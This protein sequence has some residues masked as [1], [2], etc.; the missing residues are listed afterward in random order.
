MACACQARVRDP[1]GT[2]PPTVSS[3]P[4]PCWHQDAPALDRA[5]FCAP[6]QVQVLRDREGCVVGRV[7]RANAWPWPVREKHR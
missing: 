4:V 2:S 5:P 3:R 7:F 6:G 1:A